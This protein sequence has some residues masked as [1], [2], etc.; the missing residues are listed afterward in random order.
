MVSFFGLFK[1]VCEREF[2]FS[3]VCIIFVFN[4]IGEII[5]DVEIKD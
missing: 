2:L 1:Y 4:I 3:I 5:I